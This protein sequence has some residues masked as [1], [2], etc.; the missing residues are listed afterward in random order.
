MRSIWFSLTDASLSDF[1]RPNFISF[2]NYLA[3]NEGEWI[4][5]LADPEWW[6]AVGNTFR[7]AMISVAIEVVLG[8]IFALVLNASFP[9]RGLVRAAVLVPWAVPTIVAARAFGAG[10]SMTSAG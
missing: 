8:T 6:R 5:L 4:G 1:A 9:G 2:A 7:F 3:L 10:C